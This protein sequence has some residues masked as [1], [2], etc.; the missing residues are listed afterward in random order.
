MFNRAALAFCRSLSGD[1]SDF[2]GPIMNENVAGRVR[3][4]QISVIVQY[5][6]WMMLANASNALILVTAFRKSPNWMWAVGWAAL[7]VAY[8]IYFG[9]RS[10]RKRNA[11]PITVSK[12]AVRRAIGNALLLGCLW[13]AMPLF[14]FP[15]SSTSGR[16]IITCLCAG[17]LG[18]GAFAFA[19]IPVAAIAFTSPIFIA[20]GL[21]IARHGDEAFYLVALMMI[22]YTCVILRGTFVQA[23]KLNR[24]HVEQIEAESEA[25]KDA[26]T[27]LP[28]RAAFQ[29]YVES[30]FSRMART[31]KSF[32]LLYLDLN[33]FKAVNDKMGHAAGDSL[34]VQFADRLRAT[35]RGADSS[36]RLG[37][38]EFV[39]VAPNVSNANEAWA[40]ADRIIRAVD[41]PFKI[42]DTLLKSSV[43][44]GI[45]LAPHDGA[46]FD[47]LMKNADTALYSAKRSAGKLVQIFDPEQDSY[48]RERRAIGNDLRY[49]IE[50]QE[51]YLVYQP[52]L[53][54]IED[55]IVGFE[56]LLRWAH[57]T[58]GSISP[59][60]FINIAEETQ[61]IHSIGQ[62]A[63]R[64][65]CRTAA[66][67]PSDI[68]VA[69]N[70]SVVQ[71]ENTAIL[72]TIVNALT[73]AGIMP[74]RLEIEVTK[75]VLI[76]ED[77][78]VLAMLN[79]LHHLGV[80]IA[81]DD[82]GTGY[83]SLNYLGKVPFD[84]IKIDRSFT[85]DLLNNPDRAAIVKTMIGLASDLGM[86]I[87]AE[88]VETVEQLSRLR[89]MK[90]S[91]VQGYFI[92]VPKTATEIAH[93]FK[94]RTP[95]EP[96]RLVKG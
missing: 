80:R 67:W 32:A 59:L 43:T 84:R 74:S 48:A 9:I 26:L 53:N 12:R 89:A 51:L 83:S 29:E 27:N 96:L 39:L 20:S 57:P 82:F 30:E 56:A 33:D 94:K 15:N 88:G 93:L 37:G 14:L 2:G 42:N 76:S 34:L 62:W 23:L 86:G 47:T 90:C 71:F 21:V 61:L 68:K 95:I 55:R 36:A 92:G 50:R 10:R 60:T 18:G 52:L 1:L 41:V 45:A 49:A 85:L 7:I 63:V 13:A 28:N 35:Q 3:A 46:D 25:R 31:G 79:A 70:F 40:I 22:V 78:V 64:E 19:S 69:V 66:M 65:A 75:S 72:H 73:D 44:I 4:E 81:L 58:R 91:E 8:A 24:R 38:D 16:L 77:S 5:L 54:T 87:T 11:K 17:M 6:P